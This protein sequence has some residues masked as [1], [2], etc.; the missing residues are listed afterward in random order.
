MNQSADPFEMIRNFWA[1]VPG[2]GGAGGMPGMPGMGAAAMPSFD[3]KDLE[4]RLGELK[5]VKQWLEMNMN[6]L[7][8]QI[9]TMEMQLTALNGLSSAPGMD[10]FRSATGTGGQASANAH[11]KAAADA[12]AS[13]AEAAEAAGAVGAKAFA[14]GAQALQALPWANPSE[15]IKS[16]QTAFAQ[17]Q[18]KPAK[19]AKAAGGA[20]AAKK[21]AARKSA[22]A[23]SAA[24][25]AR[26][27]P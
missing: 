27:H 18:P 25:R 19:A 24:T 12:G 2:M 11:A 20:G 16:M 21:P 9:N 13:M 8:L 5:Q 17:S 7:N 6:M 3:P 23:K 14:D 1:N 4:K 22:G 15:W 10:A 26:S